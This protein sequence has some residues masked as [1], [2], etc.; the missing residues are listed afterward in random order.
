MEGDYLELGNTASAPAYAERNKYAFGYHDVEY[1]VHT[2]SA[3]CVKADPKKTAA[4]LD[5]PTPSSVKALRGYLGLTGYNRKFIPN[6]GHIAAPLTNILKKDA[7]HWSNQADLAFQKLKSIVAAP[8]VL[9][10]P[11]FS[12]TCLTECDAS[13]IAL[14]HPYTASKVAALYVQHV[15][16]LHGMPTSIISDRDPSFTS[17]F[18]SELMTLQGVQLAMFSAYLPQTDGQTEVV[19]KSLE[20]YLR[21]FAGDRPQEWVEWEQ[22]LSLLKQTL[23]LAQ[24]IMKKQ[25]DKHRSAR[26]FQIGDWNSSCVPCFLFQEEG[27]RCISYDH[28]TSIV[29]PEPIAILQERVHL[30]RNRTITEVLVQWQGC[31][32]ENATGENL[33]AYKQ[34]FPHLVDK[35]L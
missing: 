30:L 31:A 13:G 1:L 5:W 17:A 16:K 6:Y 19:N 35:V 2:V 26:S 10:L 11:D 7:F 29:T 20:H 28:P 33:H 4:M 24:Q 27:S 25:T 21:S 34:K 9:A 12:K 3:K 8:P 18:W 14:S 15:L 22:I 23:M 32:L